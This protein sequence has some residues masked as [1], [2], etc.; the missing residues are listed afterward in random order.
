MSISQMRTY[1]LGETKQLMRRKD[2]SS[3]SEHVRGFGFSPETLIRGTEKENLQ[4]TL[5]GQPLKRKGVNERLIK[6]VTTYSPLTL[7]GGE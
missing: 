6:S 5:Q 1:R 3:L 7:L 2:K 4:A